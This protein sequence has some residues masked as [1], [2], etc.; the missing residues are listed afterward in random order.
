[1]PS[2]WWACW[3]L[4][5]P[6][7]P[8]HG[9]LHAAPCKCVLLFSRPFGLQVDVTSCQISLSLHPFPPL[10]TSGSSGRLDLSWVCHSGAL[11]SWLCCVLC[12][13]LPARLLTSWRQAS[14]LLHFC[15]YPVPFTQWELSEGLVWKEWVFLS[16]LCSNYHLPS[17]YCMHYV[18][19]H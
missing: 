12:L 10:G 13:C 3:P 11:C 2:Q 1:M 19:Y 18:V 17:S 15:V 4:V 5:S 8:S 16:G 7:C 9:E 6:V 14:C